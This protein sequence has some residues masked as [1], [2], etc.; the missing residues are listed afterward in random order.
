MTM[1]KI[2]KFLNQLITGNVFDAPEILDNYA[3]DRS[4]LKVQPKMVA[5]PE[6][7]ED[8]QKLMKFFQQVNKKGI[9]VP[10]A[11]RGSG[12]DEMGADLTN[13]VVISTEKLNRLMEIDVRERLVRVQAGITLKE[14]N[15]ALS[16]SGLMVPVGANGSETI[17]GLI[18]NC[19]TD[20]YAGKYGGI[21]NFVERA[22]VVLSNGECI[23]TGRLNKYM[24]AKKVADKTLEGK[25]YRKIYELVKN[26]KTIVE[27]FKANKV[28]SAGYTTIAYA[29]RKDTLDLLPLF[30]SA[31]G[32]LGVISE[33]ILR[34]VPIKK[35]PV[36]AIA[37]FASL[38]ST[39]KYM[40]AV[41]TLNPRQL[42]FCDLRVL[43]DVE[44]SGKNLNEIIKK[45]DFGFVVFAEFDEKTSINMR[46]LA[47]LKKT[48]PRSAK[49]ILES[50]ENRN[51]LDEFENSLVSFLNFSRN[52][53]RVPIMT[54]FYIPARNLSKF[55]DDLAVL[56]DKLGL[57]LPLFGSYMTSNYNL[58]PKFEPGSKDYN[59]KIM[60]FLK[61][62]DLVVSR[63][64][65]DLTGGAPEGRVKA[66]VTNMKMTDAEKAIYSEIKK[67]FDED[68][69]LNPDIKLGTDVRATLRHLRTTVPAKI[70]I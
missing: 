39:L 48:L 23:Q 34:A 22:E 14:L 16:V 54:D 61:A 58:R 44:K 28:S 57:D 19:P 64:E 53:E 65:G 38:G 5:L 8:I 45:M 18:S 68:G 26:N 2:T 50:A 35:N 7:T 1:S 24:V 55:V 51:T 47:G 56:E 70:V 42:N 21:M 52:G 4:V 62:G 31:Q 69:I 11:V 36:R 67:I 60:T 49:L 29:G 9:K 40:D 37:T 3:V 15:T 27:G 13:G 10:V 32:T 59:K 17:G 66:L 63:N 43:K 33:V 30:F 25:I 41:T 12:L 20:L 46:K 6:S